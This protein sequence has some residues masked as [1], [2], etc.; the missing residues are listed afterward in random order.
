MNKSSNTKE[1]KVC[2]SLPA[3]TP[4][5]IKKERE[6]MGLSQFSFSVKYGIPINTLR[7]WEQGTRIPRT[8]NKNV[9]LKLFTP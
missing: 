2:L 6:K 9:L 7:A 4:D 5:E 1:S 8:K 3:L